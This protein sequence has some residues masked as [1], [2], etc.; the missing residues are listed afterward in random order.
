VQKKIVERQ[1]RSAGDDDV[2]RIA[3]QGRGT[4]DVGGEHL[5]HEKCHRVDPETL[6]H[7]QGYRCDEQNSGHVVE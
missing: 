5:G 6:A 1:A 3:D 7:Q 2:R 4:A